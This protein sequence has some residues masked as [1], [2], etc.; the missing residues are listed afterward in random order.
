MS[1]ALAGTL[2]CIYVGDYSSSNIFEYFCHI[3]LS[4]LFILFS[5]TS[6][7]QQKRVANEDMN[8]MKPLRYGLFRMFMVI[9]IIIQIRKMAVN[10]FLNQNLIVFF[11]MVVSIQL[12]VLFPNT[13]IQQKNE[14]CKFF[15]RK[16]LKII[17]IFQIETFISVYQICLP[18]R[19]V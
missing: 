9:S 19:F 5:S 7:V 8:R 16:L 6:D 14:L 1:Q 11:F 3:S 12:F 15:D 2:T 17:I 10:L 4:L 18:Q 13:K